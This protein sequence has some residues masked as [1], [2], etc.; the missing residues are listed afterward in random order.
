MRYHSFAPFHK[1]LAAVVTGTIGWATAVV[2]SAPAAIT[3]SE[4]VFG[5]TVLATALG[6]YHVNNQ[7]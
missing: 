1:T 4:W 2:V 6:V 5:A 7:P 3:A